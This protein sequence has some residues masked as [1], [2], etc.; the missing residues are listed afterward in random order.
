MED[1][2]PVSTP[3]MTR[4]KLTKDDASPSV[5]HTTYRSM[6]RSLLYL[7]VSRPDILQAVC[8]V[9]RFQVGPKETHVAA[10]KRIFRY[11]K[12]SIDYGLWYP[13]TK[14]FTLSAYSDANWA[15]DVDDRKSTSGGAFYLGGSLV[16]WHSKKQDSVSLSTAEAEYIAAT[17][18]CT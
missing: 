11:L 5:D 8:M 10:M 17:S 12:G 15:G 3:M 4:C 1:C 13:R 9:A 2:K 6:I 16:A 18:C 14:D 7:T